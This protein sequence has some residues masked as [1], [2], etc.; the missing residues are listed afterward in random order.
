MSNRFLWRANEATLSQC[1]YCTWK[2]AGEAKCPAFPDGIP[3]LILINAADHR[4]PFTGDNG[5]RFVGMM[6]QGGK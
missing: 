1:A 2:I 4:K 5:I 3:R 6:P